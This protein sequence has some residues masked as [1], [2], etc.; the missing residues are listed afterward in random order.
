MSLISAKYELYAIPLKLVISTSLILVSKRLKSLEI[1][2]IWFLWLL[3]ERTEHDCKIQKIKIRRTWIKE[4]L[5]VDRI[6]TEYF[7]WLLCLSL[8]SLIRLV[9]HNGLNFPLKH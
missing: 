4:L 9:N 8:K 7:I 2:L 1:P 5:F 3:K 6:L